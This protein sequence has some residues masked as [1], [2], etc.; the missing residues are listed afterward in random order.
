MYDGFNFK[1]RF[2]MALIPREHFYKSSWVEYHR[3]HCVMIEDS[4]SN[5]L[6]LG[7]TIV[8]GLSRYPNVRNEYLTSINVLTLGIRGDRIKNVL[9]RAINLPLPSSIK[10]IVILWGTN[11]IPLDTPR[12]IA[13]WIISIGS[14]FRKKSNDINVSVCGLIPHDEWWLVN[15]IVTNEVN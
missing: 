4:N 7:N 11:N 9:W 1:R 10:S 6:L 5:T 14:I 12:D 8:A 15:R 2:M 3:N 13:D